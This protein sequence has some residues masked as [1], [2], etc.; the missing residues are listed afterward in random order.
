[1]ERCA[2]ITSYSLGQ[3]LPLLAKLGNRQT[4]GTPV[5]VSAF[6]STFQKYFL[7]MGGYSLALVGIMLALSN[8]TVG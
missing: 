7:M 8:V 6:A 4:Y 1:V 3:E 2:E 5:P